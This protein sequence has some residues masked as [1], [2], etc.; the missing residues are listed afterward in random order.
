MMVKVM[1]Y[2]LLV[3]CLWMIL[4]PVRAQ[5]NDP[6][7]DSV[8]I[9]LENAQVALVNNDPIFAQFLIDDAQSQL[10]TC[11]AAAVP[12]M[13]AA[14]TA[15]T[16]I[17][18][19]TSG[20][21]TLNMPT[22]DPQGS[23]A[24]ISFVHTSVDVGT[25]DI[26]AGAQEPIVSG[27]NFGEATQ[28]FPIE[29]GERVFVVRATGSG[30]T[31]QVL[32][33]RTWNLPSSTSWMITAAGSVET[34]SFQIEPLSIVRNDYGGKSRVR[35]VNFAPSSRL[36]V[37]DSS[38]ALFA[39]SLNWIGISDLLVDPGQ[40]NL[41]VTRI[42]GA[43]L[44][45][46]LPF[47]FEAE[48]TYTLNIVGRVDGEP[49]VTLLPIVTPA[50]TTRVRFVSQR[51]DTVDIHYRPTNERIAENLGNSQTTDY[52]TMPSGSVN[53]IAFAPGNG[54]TGLELASLPT[55]LRS[56]QDVTI[57]VNDNGLS[58]IEAILRQSVVGDE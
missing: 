44:S 5:T 45:A 31:G 29:S 9:A 21:F 20:D 46:I 28:L 16:V 19:V 7:L 4:L 26:Y 10:E 41:Q 30:I 55:V 43:E 17:E 57:L 2:I 51:T 6:C 14:P 1:R 11:A 35:L 58:V 42:N 15:E 54:P 23:N 25:I 8:H 39:D 36:S 53:F 37:I 47:N 48:T 38:G 27:L 33:Q 13:V 49:A 18:P 22:I 50:D 24:F 3:L 34:V 40:Y 52:V 32:A 12:T 56:G